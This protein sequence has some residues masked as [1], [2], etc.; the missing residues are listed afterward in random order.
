MTLNEIVLAAKKNNEAAFGEVS[1]KRILAIARAVF[2]EVSKQVR[3]IEEG[4]VVVA[5]LGKFLVRRKEVEKD[6]QKV[7]QRRIAFRPAA[8]K[9]AGTAGK[10]GRSAKSGT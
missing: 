6:G 7:V 1:E 8:I 5:G 2:D 9:A 3:V 4:Q 10:A